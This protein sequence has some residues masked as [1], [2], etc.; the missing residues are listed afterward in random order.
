MARGAARAGRSDAGREDRV[1]L[2]SHTRLCPAALR[3]GRRSRLPL[4]R[5]ADREACIRAQVCPAIRVRRR[6]SGCW[7]RCPGQR[8]PKCA[9]IVICCFHRR[10]YAWEYSLDSGFHVRHLSDFDSRCTDPSLIRVL[11]NTR[12]WIVVATA[13]LAIVSWIVF[14]SAGPWHPGLCAVS[15]SGFK[16]TPNDV[17]YH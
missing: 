11:F 14:A 17:C 5:R 15:L 1:Q 12:D 10:R 3:H 13:I 7:R 4:V 16:L 8:R 9:G 6:S 2:S